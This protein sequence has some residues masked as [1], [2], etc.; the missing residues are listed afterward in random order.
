VILNYADFVAETLEDGHPAT[1][2]VAET[3][4]ATE[5]AASLTRQL[6]V[7]SR[8]DSSSSRSTSARSRSTR[9][10]LARTSR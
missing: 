10:M 3:S 1:A 4:G 7:F 6:L 2:D 9:C 5:R 8:H